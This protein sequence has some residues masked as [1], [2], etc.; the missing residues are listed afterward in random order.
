MMSM[1][2]RAPTSTLVSV[3]ARTQPPVV[4]E[5][6]RVLGEAWP[7]PPW[8]PFWSCAPPPSL[9]RGEV[10]SSS[11]STSRRQEEGRE[12]QEAH[13]SGVRHAVG[14]SGARGTTRPCA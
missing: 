10:F 5:E 3:K 2:A 12:S 9:S 7:Y 14:G 4:Q 11:T 1:A 13:P 6:A 8:S